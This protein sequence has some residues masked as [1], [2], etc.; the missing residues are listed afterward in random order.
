MKV[1]DLIVRKCIKKSVSRYKDVGIVVK[2]IDTND[3]TVYWPTNGFKHTLQKKL[4]YEKFEV[5]NE[6]R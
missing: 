2:I 4:F 5:L 1:G 6:S 3:V